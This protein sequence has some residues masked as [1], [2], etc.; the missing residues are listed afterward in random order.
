M[1]YKLVNETGNTHTLKRKKMNFTSYSIFTGKAVPGQDNREQAMAALLYQVLADEH[2]LALFA[3]NCYW[4]TDPDNQA[5]V[6]RYHQRFCMEMDIVI[7]A[8]RRR[9][10]DTGY[11]T[12]GLLDEMLE[13]V[14]NEAVHYIA[15]GKEQ[16]QLLQRRHEGLRNRL[17]RYL[18]DACKCHTDGDLR[19][20]LVGLS[21]QHEQWSA[22]LSIHLA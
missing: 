7:D 6:Q 21:R 14:C 17:Y 10:C 2:R 9:L 4:Y 19:E 16:L 22:H 3:R 18:Y 20:F 8:V 1:A 11:Y 15:N 13:D 12:E 5:T